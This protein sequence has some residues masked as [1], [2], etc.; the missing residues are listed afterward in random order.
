MFSGWFIAMVHICHLCKRKD[1]PFCRMVRCS[2]M[3]RLCRRPYFLNV[4]FPIPRVFLLERGKPIMKLVGT[5]F[6]RIG[7]VKRGEIQKDSVD[8][9]YEH[10]QVDSGRKTTSSRHLYISTKVYRIAKPI[11]KFEYCS[12]STFTSRANAHAG[13]PRSFPHLWH[14]VKFKSGCPVEVE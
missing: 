6:Q 7:H 4:W 5:T 11:N 12:T 1:V 3:L 9:H 10:S 2:V 13:R 14:V 8:K